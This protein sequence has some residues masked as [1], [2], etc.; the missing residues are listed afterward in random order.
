MASNLINSA[1]VTSLSGILTFCAVSP[2]GS[3]NGIGFGFLIFGSFGGA[4]GSRGGLGFLPGL[5][6]AVGDTLAAGGG[7]VLL[8]GEGLAPKGGGVSSAT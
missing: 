3:G 8:M 7:G 5:P 1:P 2:M 4:L 6:G